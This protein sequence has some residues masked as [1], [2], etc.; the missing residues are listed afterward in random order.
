[1]KTERGR[2]VDTLGEDL[3]IG[4]SM[5]APCLFSTAVMQTLPVDKPLWAM[6]VHI[7]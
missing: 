1:M 5:A 7:C 3:L 4:S 6:D 2:G